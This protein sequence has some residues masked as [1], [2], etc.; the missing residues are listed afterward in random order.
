MRKSPV[1]VELDNAAKNLPGKKFVTVP[2]K[3]RRRRRKM[4]PIWMY[5]QMAKSKGLAGDEPE[6]LP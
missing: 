4:K 6:I 5:V 1:G 3:N 2:R